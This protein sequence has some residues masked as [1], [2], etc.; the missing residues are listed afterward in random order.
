MKKIDQ[1]IMNLMQLRY[2]ILLFEQNVLDYDNYIE[3]NKLTK[4]E[5]EK[6]KDILEILSYIDSEY[7]KGII[8]DKFIYSNKNM[9]E[10]KK[11][12]GLYFLFITNKNTYNEAGLITSKILELK[13]KNKSNAPFEDYLNIFNNYINER[14]SNNFLSELY[15]SNILNNLDDNYINL[16]F[17]YLNQKNKKNLI[18]KIILQYN[19]NN[20]DRIIKLITELSKKYPILSNIELSDYQLNILIGISDANYLKILNDL[21]LL[22]L[23]K[24]DA[25]KL[26]KIAL[27]LKKYDLGLFLYEN[28][29]V[30]DNFKILKTLFE[31]TL[32]DD[33]DKLYGL[34]LSV[35][36]SP[37]F[38]KID[39]NMLNYV[40]TEIM[41]NDFGKKQKESEFDNPDDQKIKLLRKLHVFLDEALDND[42]IDLD[43]QE[44]AEDLFIEIDEMCEYNDKIV[45]DYN[46]MLNNSNNKALAINKIKF[47]EELMSV[48]IDKIPEK[49]HPYLIKCYDEIMNKDKVIQ[50]QKL[51]KTLTNILNKNNKKIER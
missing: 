20:K 6:L 25:L 14:L 22:K 31:P 9:N 47:V 24:C 2:G 23:N 27:D 50:Q 18:S 11:E 37:K 28:C 12:L 45:S 10:L 8:N 3:Y 43:I 41:N 40:K 7:E 5:F 21:N 29:N 1:K 35:I 38:K 30:N 34:L 49:K 39:I 42:Y 44:Q 48:L 51:I 32:F 13:S 15:I 17:K 46:L 26:L 33:I 19:C 16:E 36:K 4:I